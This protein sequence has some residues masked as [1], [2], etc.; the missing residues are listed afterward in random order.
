MKRILE[1]EKVNPHY[2]EV[3]ITESVMM[4]IEESSLLIEELKEVGVRI[5]IVDF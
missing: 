2:F 5:A 1:E 3:E 4:N